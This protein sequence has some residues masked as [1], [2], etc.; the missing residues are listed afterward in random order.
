MSDAI[1]GFNLHP[2][3]ADIAKV[4]HAVISEFEWSRFIFLYENSEYLSI[5]NSL[6]SLYGTKGPIISVLR[7]D[8]NLNGN[9]KAVLRRVRKSVDSRIVVVGSTVS[10]AELLK[11][12]NSSVEIC[13]LSVFTPFPKPLYFKFKIIVDLIS[14]QGY[15]F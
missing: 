10:V 6:L 13:T 11:Q 5:L 12:V 7:Y 14:F 8:L 3:P 4:L 2:H 15:C 1:E 9:F